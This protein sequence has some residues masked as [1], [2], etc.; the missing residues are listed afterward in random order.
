MQEIDESATC[1]QALCQILTSLLDDLT[2]NEA[3]VRVAAD[4]DSLHNYRV[5][6]R[7]ARVV[8]KRFKEIMPSNA[9]DY[10]SAELRWLGQLTSPLRDADTLLAALDEYNKWLPEELSPSLERLRDHLQQVQLSERGIIMTALA[11][12]KYELFITY[13]RAFVENGPAGWN[14]QAWAIYAGV[15]GAEIWRQYRKMVRRGRGIGNGSPAEALHELRKDGKKLRYL[16]EFFDMGAQSRE[17]EKLLKQLRRLQD[18]LGAHQDYEVH[19]DRVLKFGDQLALYEKASYK[20]FLG[21]GILTGRLNGLQAAARDNFAA[22]FKK[23][24]SKRS[25]RHFRILCNI[26]EIGKPDQTPDSISQAP[27]SL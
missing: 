19:A 13:W 25:K 12:K 9:A 17:L 8:V 15:A 1:G 3:G 22:N 11:G 4:I 16:I 27:D 26:E 6:I 2:L 24:S 10:F 21:L 14:N 23:F 7:R 5:A 20:D 18:I